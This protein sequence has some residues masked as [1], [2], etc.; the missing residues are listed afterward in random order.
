MASIPIAP[1]PMTSA[2][3]G[4]QVWRSP[5]RRAWRMPRTQT[6]AGSARTPRRPRP[7]GTRTSW[8]GSSATTSRA[9]PCRRGDPALGVAAGVARV[10]RRRRAGRARA[11]AAADRRRDEVAGREAPAVL[12]H[13]AEQL[14]TEDEVAVAVGRDTERALGDLAVR[15]ADAD[16]ERAQ[17]HGAGR[18]G[19]RRDRADPRRAGPAGRREERL[20][21]RR[22]AQ[23]GGSTSPRSRSSS[24]RRTDVRDA[25]LHRAHDRPAE[26]RDEARP[27]D[28][29]DQ[30]E[31]AR[32]RR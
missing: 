10:G 18:A 28:R 17:A 27:V 22:A 24:N 4:R 29:L 13:L 12:E 16:L 6:D 2:R 30:R 5:T 11:A 7:A 14:V 1:A 3:R 8:A 25:L 21:G 32:R 31:D 23:A 19:R 9:K 20:H 26:Q 15:A